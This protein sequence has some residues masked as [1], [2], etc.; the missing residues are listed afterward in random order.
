MKKLLALFTLAIMIL[1]STA[2]FAASK[3][4]LEEGADLKAIK[5]LAIALPMH[6]KTVETEPTVEEF[7]EI[8]Y[9]GSKSSRCY[10]IPYSEMATNIK[11]TSGVDIKTLKTLD[12]M[13][14]FQKDVGKFADAYLLVTTANNS[15]KPQ[16][17]FE[18]YNTDGKLMYVYTVQ[19]GDYGKNSKD[20]QKACEDFFKKLDNAIEKGV[21]EPDKDKNK[22][23]SMSDQ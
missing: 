20:Y 4:T 12:A 23:M 3:E 6:Y 11:K 8:I 5:R 22:L 15:S 10:V 14:A 21:K 9:I 16:F 13:K 17:F 19:S 2:A 7:T 1:T 18:I